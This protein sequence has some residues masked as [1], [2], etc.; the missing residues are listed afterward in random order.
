MI[1]K[2]VTR[3]AL[4]L[5][6]GSSVLSGC[7]T[8]ASNESNLDPAYLT[9]AQE[10]WGDTFSTGNTKYDQC[11]NRAL[12]EHAAK[13]CGPLGLMGGCFG[14]AG[15]GKYLV[16]VNAC[17]HLPAPNRI[18][19]KDEATLEEFCKDTDWNDLPGVSGKYDMPY[20]YEPKYAKMLSD[21]CNQLHRQSANERP[22]K[23]GKAENISKTVPSERAPNTAVSESTL[24]SGISDLAESIMRARQDGERMAIMMR[25][26][27]N[28]GS[29]LNPAA[30]IAFQG[31]Q[32]ELTQMAYQRP[33]YGTPAI[34]EQVITE[35]GND[36]YRMCLDA[37]K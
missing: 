29:D 23:R 30:K 25:F 10:T 21:R 18:L 15:R 27:D 3:T 17:G 16:V 22:E 34:K 20:V 2:I 11:A 5:I 32:R 1:V 6:L 35:F 36:A 19:P 8:A 14:A 4:A 24:C 7:T 12:V 28:A 13:Q 31:M 33:R 37:M 26:A 9:K